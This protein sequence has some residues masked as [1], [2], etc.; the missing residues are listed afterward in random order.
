MRLPRRLPIANG[1]MPRSSCASPG[2]DPF[3]GERAAYK[4]PRAAT[5]IVFDK[6]IGAFCRGL[7]GLPSRPQR[8]FDS[9]DGPRRSRVER[10]G[11]KLSMGV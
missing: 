5:H 3:A 10:H 2:L 11:Y 4:P 8:C 6:D 1:S 7:I 9:N